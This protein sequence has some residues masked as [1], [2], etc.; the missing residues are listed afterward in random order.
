MSKR[1]SGKPKS[2]VNI[3]TLEDLKRVLYVQ[4][5]IAQECRREMMAC[6]SSQELA[7]GKVSGPEELRRIIKAQT[8]LLEKYSKYPT[9]SEFAFHP[10]L[11][12][13]TKWGSTFGVAIMVKALIVDQIRTAMPQFASFMRS[14][15]LTI[16]KELN[17]PQ[18]EYLIEPLEAAIKF[19]V[20]MGEDGEEINDERSK[21][22][23]RKLLY[24]V[25][26][27]LVMVSAQYGI[28]EQTPYGFG[29]TPMGRRILL[30]MIDADIFLNELV[31]AHKQFQAE[32]PKINLV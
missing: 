16:I 24:Q 2:L 19:R 1:D 5:I 13:A 7:T 12:A 31:A 23:T 27:S 14:I 26:E 29:I 17:D 21:M 3:N 4:K 25:T 6:A 18:H 10:V 32:K 20:T 9:F 28:V 8:A 11:G 22:L 15:Y 30:H